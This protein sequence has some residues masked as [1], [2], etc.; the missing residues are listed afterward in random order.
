[1]RTVIYFVAATV[2]LHQQAIAQ[3]PHKITGPLGVYHGSPGYTYSDSTG[4]DSTLVQYQ[5]RFGEFA[6]SNQAVDNGFVFVPD[7]DS[8]IKWN[9]NRVIG[10]IQPLTEAGVPNQPAD[11]SLYYPF[12]LGNHPGMVQGGHR[13]SQLSQIYGPFCGAILDDWN[14]DSATTE[15]VHDALLGKYMDDTGK[16]YS[17][18]VATTPENKLYCVIYNPTPVPANLLPLIDGVSY[19]YVNGQNCCYDNLD[20]DISLLRTNFPHKEIMIGIY[21]NG[22]VGWMNKVGIEYLLQNSFN[23]YDEGYINGVTLFAGPLLT[24][25]FMPLAVWDSIPLP[26]ILDSFYYPYLG[27]GQGKLYDCATN[28]TL[29][30]AFIRVYCAGRLSGD[31]LMR[32]RQKSD[33]TGQYQFGLWAGNRSTDSTYYWL[34]AEKSGYANDTLGFWIKRNQT[35]TIPDLY[36]CTSTLNS[37][38]KEDNMLVFPN[39]GGS[40]FTV[41]VNTANTASGLLEIYNIL[42]K[43]VY[44]GTQP[45]YHSV[46]DLSSEPDGIYFIRVTSGTLGTALTRILD[47]QH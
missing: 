21:I 37:E 2:L 23:S 1:M 38:V 18:S 43:K 39:P 14:M 47:L 28:A 3:S 44:S 25:D 5:F 19:W 26:S 33:S 11:T 4:T 10:V 12:P 42:G 7:I 41:E 13:F 36:L 16:V 22:N 32:S 20:G 35:T 34:I 6:I 27:M 15:Q 31:T 9:A 30:N 17:N 45:L 46:I 29:N 40:I 24:K 8:C